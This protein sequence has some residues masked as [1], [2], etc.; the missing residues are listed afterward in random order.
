LINRDV[1]RL[2]GDTVTVDILVRGT[3]SSPKVDIDTDKLTKEITGRIEKAA[4][5]EIDKQK[6]DLEKKAKDELEKK[7]KEEEEKLKKELEK[8][9]AE[10]KN[11][12]KDKLKDLL[13]K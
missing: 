13:G 6:S 12:V 1:S 10:G 9:A 5:K 4:K 11:K 2:T 7:K 8:K 3:I